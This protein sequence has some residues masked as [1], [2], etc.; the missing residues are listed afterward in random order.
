MRRLAWAVLAA[1]LCSAALGAPGFAQSGEPQPQVL[2][3]CPRMYAWSESFSWSRITLPVGTSRKIGSPYASYFSS[4]LPWE[5]V[6]NGVYSVVRHD[7]FGI[8]L[9]G[10]SVGQSTIRFRIPELPEADR[11]A[12]L[13]DWNGRIYRQGETI[14]LTVEVIPGARTT[15]KVTLSGVGKLDTDKNRSARLKVKVTAAKSSGKSPVNRDL[16]WASDNLGVLTVDQ[17][18]LVTAVA[19][20]GATVSAWNSEGKVGHRF[21]TVS[22]VLRIALSHK[23]LSLRPGQEITVAAAVSG[24]AAD[25]PLAVRTSKPGIV[26]V[27]KAEDGRFTVRARG[28]GKAD[29][30]ISDLT[31]KW[32]AACAVTVK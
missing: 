2:Y 6:D 32:K 27:A 18:G 23:K 31:G 17:T 19:P 10:Q 20:G 22:K 25:E 5:P 4:A 29:V 24:G 1:L 12:V 9:F 21:I 14:D 30:V 28:V 26:E 15:K 7:A 8:E 3:P 11:Q 13:F 16:V